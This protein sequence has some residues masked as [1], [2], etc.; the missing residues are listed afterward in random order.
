MGCKASF[1][2]RDFSRIRDFMDP[3]V[4]RDNQLFCEDVSLAHIAAEHGT[5]CYVYSKAFLRSRCLAYTDA[6]ATHKHLICYSVK[7]SSNV[8]LLKFFSQQGLG[9]DIVSGGELFRAKLAGVPGHRIVYSGVGKSPEEIRSALAYEILFFNV[10][11]E[12]ELLLINQIAAEMNLIAPV[13]LRVNPDVDPLTHPYISTGLKENKFGIPIENAELIYLE[14]AQTLKNIKFV[15]VDCHIGSQLINLAPFRDTALRLRSLIESLASNN[16]QLEFVDVGGGLG[17]LYDDEKVPEVVQLASILT[18]VLAGLGLTIVLEPGRSLVGNSAVMLTKV[19]YLKDNSEKKFAIVDA[20]MND[21]LRPSLY[22][23]FQK[24]ELV[25]SSKTLD[26]NFS[27]YDI[28]G[29][30]CESGDFLAKDRS[31]PVLHAG[32]LLAVR[33]AGAY[34]FSMSSN[35]NS[36]PRPVELLVDG[37]SV[38]VIKERETYEDLVRGESIVS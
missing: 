28:V 19:Q 30:I 10:E 12:P 27:N 21:M 35:Y 36:R 25:D 24:I 8:N 14:A 37:S 6:F 2:M 15:G 33:S 1:G 18:E 3:F 34:G 32:D 38:S 23:A 4:Y 20:G 16:L 17:I 13:T 29:P 11:S 7:A 26:N 9:C 31:F 22:D 5:P